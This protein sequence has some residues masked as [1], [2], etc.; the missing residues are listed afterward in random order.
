MAVSYNCSVAH[1]RPKL[2]AEEALYEYAIRTLTRRS[3][4]VQELRK[5]LDRRTTKC[6]VREKV[7][8]RLTRAGYLDDE[9]LADAYVSIKKDHESLGSRRVL[10]DLRRRG[11]SKTTAEKV[12]FLAYKEVTEDQLI[13]RQLKRKLGENFADHKITDHKKI[14]A[15]YRSLVRAGFSSDK[16]GG[17]LR[18][19]APDADLPADFSDQPP[20][21]YEEVFD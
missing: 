7:M 3:L 10:M 12:V 2:L 11:V 17:V 4:T 5:R 9:K 14:L 21:L 18:T 1:T 20:D 13:T 15:L 6:D 19:I 8:D 16:I